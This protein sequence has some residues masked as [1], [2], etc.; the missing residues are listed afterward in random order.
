[1]KLRL[2]VKCAFG[3][4][5]IVNM[6]NGSAR[7]R[8]PCQAASSSLVRGVARIVLTYVLIAAAHKHDAKLVLFQRVST[9][10]CAA[11]DTF[12]HAILFSRRATIIFSPPARR[13]HVS[14]FRLRRCQ[15][16][17]FSPFIY[18][19]L[20]ITFWQFNCDITEFIHNWSRDC[21]QFKQKTSA[22]CFS[23]MLG[24]PIEMLV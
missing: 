7:H 8:P 6:S 20:S 4:I 16:A 24:G 10:S 23:L 9:K 22:R 15:S 18:W 14:C 11:L 21:F 1:M 19:L 2:P 17:S 12:H 13:T 3:K 5:N